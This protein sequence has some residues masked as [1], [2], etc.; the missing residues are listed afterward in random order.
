MSTAAPRG[1]YFCPSVRP[2]VESGVWVGGGGGV[3]GVGGGLMKDA[4]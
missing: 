3:E 2:H 4:R 1:G